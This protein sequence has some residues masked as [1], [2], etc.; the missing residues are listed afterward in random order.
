[1]WQT[2]TASILKDGDMG[3]TA[4]IDG[5]IKVVSKASIRRHLKLEDSDSIN[6][7]STAESF[8]QLALMGVCSLGSDKGSL[9]LNELTVL[10]TQ[11]STK[12]ASLEED[13][14][15][16]KKVYGNAYTKLILKV[17]KLEKTIKTSQARRRAKIVVSDDEEDEEDSSKQGRSLIKDMDLDAGISLVPLH[18]VDQ[19]RF[20]D[21]HVSDKL[22]E[23]LGVFSAAKVLA[24]AARIR[25]EVE[26]VE[27]N[28]PSP[29]ATKDKGKAIMQESE[30][31]KKIKKRVQIQMSI[32][33]E[34]AQKLHEEEQARF[35]VEQK[36][37]FNEE[38][39]Q[40]RLDY[41]AAVRIQEE[42]DESERQRIYKQF[43]EL[44]NQR[45]KFFAQ[46]RVEAKRNKPMTPV[47]QKAYMSTYMS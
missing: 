21:T 15:Q 36:A 39:E 27:I 44:V 7:L 43:V 40:K 32:D 10:C 20:D 3:I 28:I 16:T 37:K 18:V 1:F 4:T 2:A 26:N 41:E 5:K 8:K 24:D 22:E 30:P 47:Q 13:L 11:L 38:Q 34:L 45:K 25:R 35:N 14:K 9:T 33:E 6:T 23:Q 31:L 46:Q 42:M 19:G 17:K 12:V 29:V